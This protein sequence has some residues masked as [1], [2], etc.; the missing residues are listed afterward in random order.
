MDDRPMLKLK[1][2]EWVVTAYAESC[3]G[4][5]WTN[6]PIIAIIQ[7]AEGKIRQEYIQPEDQS[8]ELRLLFSI[9]EDVH[10]AMRATVTRLLKGGKK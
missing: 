8:A 10:L 2:D 6:L 1:K 4:P 7:N 3:M 9:S 5:G